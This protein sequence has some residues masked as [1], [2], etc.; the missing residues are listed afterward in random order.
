MATIKDV[1]DRAG[2]TVTTVSRM[3][4]RPGK[5]HPTTIR[6]IQQAMRELDY[7]PNEIARSLSKKTSNMIGLIVPSARNAFFAKVIDSTERAAAAN[8]LKLLLCVS[9]HER[10]KEIEYFSMLKANK[11]AGVIIASHTQD[12]AESVAFDAPILSV[13]RMISPRIPSVCSDNFGGGQ[14]AAE[15]LIRKG[16][17][18]VAYFSGGVVLQGM[19]ASL[20][21]QG[22]EQTLRAH[23]LEPVIQTHPEER[24][25]TMDYQDMIADFLALHGEIDGAFCSNDVLAAELIRSV[26]RKGIAVPEQLRVIGYDD[27]D[28]AALFMPSITT[29]RQPVEDI[30]RF[31]VESIAHFHERPIPS[32]TI[33]PVQLVEREST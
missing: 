6:R 3:L 4:N 28:L 15:L 27:I 16:C 2:V 7:R 11:V 22:F 12:L 5:V 1:A 10:Q 32:Q 13:D 31:A 25:I 8:G 14:L 33:F 20:R 23:G 17:R 9:N 19:S 21:Q 29:L 26:T 18:R 30:S 24:F